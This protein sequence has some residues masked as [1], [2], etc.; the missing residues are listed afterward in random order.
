MLQK[1]NEVY[2]SGDEFFN[3]INTL[4]SD[5]TLTD[6][7]IVKWVFGNE[8]SVWKTNQPKITKREIQ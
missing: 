6:H 1:I 3:V 7:V 4:D 8:K 5:F 2:I